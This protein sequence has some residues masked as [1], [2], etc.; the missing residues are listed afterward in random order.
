MAERPERIKF[1]GQVLAAKKRQLEITW[2]EGHDPTLQTWND[3]VDYCVEAGLEKLAKAQQ[4]PMGMHAAE[5]YLK[6]RL[7][8]A[9][10]DLRK[11]EYET[12]DYDP[13]QF[14]KDNG[15]GGN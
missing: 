2:R 11:A 3:V 1:Q 13:S 5:V 15:S 12:K 7:M 6:K 10:A 8:E 4:S 9:E 14:W